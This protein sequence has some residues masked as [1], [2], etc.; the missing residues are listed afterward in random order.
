MQRTKLR[1]TDVLRLGQNLANELTKS[2][3]FVVN[4]NGLLLVYLRPM[5]SVRRTVLLLTR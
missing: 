1:A 3:S 5:A 2:D 4:V